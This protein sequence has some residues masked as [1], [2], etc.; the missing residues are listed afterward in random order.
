MSLRRR[1]KMGASFQ[2][3][4]LPLKKS[5]VELKKE[6]SKMQQQDRYENGHEY[7]G[8]FGMASGLK[9]NFNTFATSKAAR[10]WISENAEKW[11]NASAVRVPS[12]KVWVIGAWCAE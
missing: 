1:M 10:E 9:I 6:F 3:A 2:T 5:E 12:E 11:E 4:S 7:S 8:G